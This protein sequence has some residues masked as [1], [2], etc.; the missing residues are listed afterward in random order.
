MAFT[1]NY[2]ESVIDAIEAD[3]GASLVTEKD[4]GVG[5]NGVELVFANPDNNPE[6]E[7]E[8]IAILVTGSAAVRSVEAH[9]MGRSISTGLTPLMNLLIH[10]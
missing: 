1:D 6:W 3:L 9:E 10:F 5:G 8:D 7:F 4:F 2:V